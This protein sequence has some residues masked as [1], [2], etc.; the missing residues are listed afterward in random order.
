MRVHIRRHN[1]RA[2]RGEIPGD[3]A[4]DATRDKN[5]PAANAVACSLAKCLHRFMIVGRRLFR[6]LL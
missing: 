5:C 1:T 4:A 3:A 2:G 6:L